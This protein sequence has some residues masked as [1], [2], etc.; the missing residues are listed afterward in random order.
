MA[1]QTCIFFVISFYNEADTGAFTYILI[2]CDFNN[3]PWYASL[4][5]AWVQQ[6]EI[7]FVI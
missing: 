5:D 7:N 2:I 3:L 1:V 4:C 6:T